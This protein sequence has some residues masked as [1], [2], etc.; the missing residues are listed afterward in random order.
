M[1]FDLHEIKIISLMLKVAAID[2]RCI[3]Q[4]L[5]F[6]DFILEYPHAEK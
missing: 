3:Q 1:P 5:Y 6:N 2:E 4:N